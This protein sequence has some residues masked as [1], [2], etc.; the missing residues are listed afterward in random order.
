MS[1]TNTQMDPL[2]LCNSAD[3]ETKKTI[4]KIIPH[5]RWYSTAD[6]SGNDGRNKC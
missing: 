2:Y 3:K 1:K 6:Y 5:W 4:M